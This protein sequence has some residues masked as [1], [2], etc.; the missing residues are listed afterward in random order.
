MTWRLVCEEES[1]VTWTDSRCG[2]A[3]GGRQAPHTLG[4]QGW[5]VFTSR[6]SG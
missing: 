3:G 6:A 1:T 2:G 5:E 4:R